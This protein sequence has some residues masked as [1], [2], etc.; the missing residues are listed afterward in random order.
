[1]PHGLC[2]ASRWICVTTSAEWQEQL[3]LMEEAACDSMKSFAVTKG[4]GCI[5]T[6]WSGWK[7]FGQ[8]SL[9]E[10]QTVRHTDEE[11]RKRIYNERIQLLINGNLLGARQR[12]G[13]LR[14]QFLG[15]RL[16]EPPAG[17]YN[18]GVPGSNMMVSR[19]DQ[20][21]ELQNNRHTR[22]EQQWLG[23]CDGWIRPCQSSERTFCSL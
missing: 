6:I 3:T 13:K 16:K 2:R 5:L 4:V 23:P 7:C 10:S 1:M 15:V 22:H 11:Q 17:P 18:F 21:T 9:V 20:I 8:L 12:S 14:L 19:Q